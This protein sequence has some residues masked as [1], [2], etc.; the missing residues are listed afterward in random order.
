MYFF[1]LHQWWLKKPKERMLYY[2]N[3][4]DV[5]ITTKLLPSLKHKLNKGHMLKIEDEHT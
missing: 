4:I 2:V 1:F 3:N 5:K